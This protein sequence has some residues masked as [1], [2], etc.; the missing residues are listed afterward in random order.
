LSVSPRFSSR[1]GLLAIFV[2]SGFAGLIYQSIWSHYLGLFL[3]HAAYAQALVLA[4]FM[5]GMA[6]GAA[7]VGHAGQRW[8]NLV[9]AYALIEA[10][11]GCLGLLFH[12]IFTGVAALSYDWLIPALGAPWAIDV[13][14]W[15]MAALLILP[16]T[17]LLGM[18]FPLMS[19][20]LM[21]RYPA[22]AGRLL[23]GLYFTNSIGAAI[24]AL[25][26]VFI[27]LPWVGLPGAMGVAGILNF[28]VA[29]LAWWLAREPE[30]EPEHAINLAAGATTTT[31]STASTTNGATGS[32]T[33]T[34]PAALKAARATP[35]AQPPAAPGA[36]R[37]SLVRR[38]LFC[39]RNCLDSPAQH[40]VGS[41]LHAFELMLASFILGI[42]L[43][44]LWVRNHAD[45]T[46]SPLRLVGWMQL[47]MGVAALASLAVYANAFGWVGCPD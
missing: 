44:G 39:V 13:A 42:A 16:Q 28:G 15:T 35:A 10:V 26:A 18:T 4:I 21:R 30:P 11:I 25:V 45:A 43:G 29:A 37:H 12:G 7:W 41:T 32:A 19:G 36:V 14:R 1:Q 33:G 34:N 23:G 47:G 17:I 46:A 27:L 22:R 40:G 9:R 20:G 6:L 8:R 5:G 2:L 24:G 38:G 31:S 3:G